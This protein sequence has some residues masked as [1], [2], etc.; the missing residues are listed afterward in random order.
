MV[1]KDT[2]ITEYDETNYA[3][4]IQTNESENTGTNQSDIDLLENYNRKLRNIKEQFINEFKK[5]FMGIM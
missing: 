2:P 5:L 1:V 3:S 4:G